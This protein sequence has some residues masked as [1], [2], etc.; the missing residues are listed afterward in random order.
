MQYI[1]V[2]VAAA[3]LR[4][5][6]FHASEMVSQLLL[7]ETALVLETE[8]KFIKIKTVYNSYEGW[9][10]TIQ[11]A[12]IDEAIAFLKPKTFTTHRADVA[13]FNGSAVPLSIGTPVFS[14]KSIGKY[15]IEYQLANKFY[16]FH[17]SENSLKQITSWYVNVPYLWG[18]RSSFGIDC[19]GF[20]QKVFQFFGKELPRDAS[21][22][23]VQGG[24]IGFLQE[25]KPGDLAFFDNDEGNIVHVGIL[26]TPSS[27][28]HAS[29]KVQI[30]FVDHE[31]IIHAESRI[32]THHLRCIKRFFE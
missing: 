25:A 8:K 12:E 10:Q 24:D 16:S 7:G 11:T 19:S 1:S 21:M 2:I 5:E 9:I 13:L 6:P 15:T 28:I 20:T 26:L 22:Q 23:A 14:Y 30:D 17:F 29:G 32:R 3:P 4:K 27:I 31:G 18:G